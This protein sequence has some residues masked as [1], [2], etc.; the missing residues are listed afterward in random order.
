MRTRS[1]LLAILLAALGLPGVLITPIPGYAAPVPGETT[2]S[3]NTVARDY[4]AA[5][6]LATSGSDQCGLPLAARKGA[7]LCLSQTTTRTQPRTRPTAVNG[8]V[9]IQS[10]VCSALGCYYYLD[11][12]YVYFDGTGVYGYGGTH[13]GD[14]YFY[15]EDKFSGGRSYSQRF[16]FESTRG[17]R[18]LAATGERLYFSTAHPEGYPISSGAS[19]Q[20]WGPYG[21]YAAGTLVTA[22]GTTGYTYYDSSVAWAGIAHEFTWTDPSSAYPGR[23]YAWW[24]SPKFQKQ[25][26]GAYTTTNPPT[27][28]SNWYGSGYSP[29]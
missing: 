22:F 16:Q 27:M 12:Y 26:S 24:K 7:W 14:L 20:G 29:F 11:N 15:V 21:P 2:T 9:G 1:R 10:G 23:W 28:G 17:V 13:L 18:T 8:D 25:S 4:T 3:D 6:Q 19:Q 5:G